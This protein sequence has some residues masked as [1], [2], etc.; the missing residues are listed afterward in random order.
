M[1]TAKEIKEF[2]E[3]EDFF[4]FICHFVIIEGTIKEKENWVFGYETEKS[5][6]FL[7]Q[8][9]GQT[10][11]RKMVNEKI[12]KNTDILC[13]DNISLE[14]IEDTGDGYKIKKAT[15]ISEENL[16]KFLENYH[17]NHDSFLNLDEIMSRI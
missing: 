17:F 2:C 13:L 6:A 16:F 1:K 15:Y 5:P 11:V 7:A 9:D 12:L 8:S 10:I 4:V 3:K 14:E